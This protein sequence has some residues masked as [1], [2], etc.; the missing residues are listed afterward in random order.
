MRNNSVKLFFNLEQL[1]RRCLLKIF[2]L[3]LL[4]PSCSVE[5][6]HLCKRASWGTFMCSYLKFRPVVQEEMSFKEKVYGRQTVDDRPTTDDGRRP[7]TIPYAQV[8]R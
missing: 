7:F 2:Y 4:S 6:N 8:S 1:F 5:Q 3:E